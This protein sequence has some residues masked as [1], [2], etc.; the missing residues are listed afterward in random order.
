MVITIK[1]VKHN[2]IRIRNYILIQNVFKRRTLTRCI[3]NK[4]KFNK[5]TIIF[6]KFKSLIFNYYILCTLYI[7]MYVNN[8]LQETFFSKTAFIIL[9]YIAYEH[10]Y[11]LIGVFQKLNSFNQIDV[12]N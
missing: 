5:L 7:P 12:L 6:L 4:N 10:K 11:V 3:L 9:N 1:K 8:T 2:E